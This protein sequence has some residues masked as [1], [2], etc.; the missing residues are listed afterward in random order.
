[1]S[2]FETI[3]FFPGAGS[4]GSEFSE[5]FRQVRP[6]GQ[7]IRY[8]GRTDPNFGV[9]ARSFEALVD[10]CVH[11]INRK[12]QKPFALF[13]HS[14]G[15][16]VAFACTQKLIC[17]GHPPKTLLVTGA[18]CPGTSLSKPPENREDAFRYFEAISRPETEIKGSDWLET[19]VDLGLKDLQLL[20]K[21]SFPSVPQK[22]NCCIHVLAGTD[23]PLVSDVGIAKWRQ[24]STEKVDI[25]RI[26]GGHTDILENLDINDFDV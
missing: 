8:P 25:R 5:L 26:P 9:P 11:K 19:T 2:N 1:M 3:F 24:A 21:Y 12:K 6:N 15:A 7:L 23:D 13:G 18:N 14:F 20:Y 22:V 4:Y 17:M 10:F 16:F